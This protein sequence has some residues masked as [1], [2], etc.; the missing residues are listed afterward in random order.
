MP[1]TAS[2]VENITPVL[3]SMT[4]QLTIANIML[5]LAAGLGAG[6][7]FVLGWFGVRKL[8]SIIM[9]AFKKGTVKI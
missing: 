6:I 5:V 4:S 3:E 8:V 1:T 9:A 2:L 7:V